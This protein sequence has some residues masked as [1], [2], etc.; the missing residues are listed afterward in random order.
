MTVYNENNDEGTGCTEQ[1]LLSLAAWSSLRAMY[2]M[3]IIK[4]LSMVGGQ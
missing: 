1:T 3:M 2:L 4:E